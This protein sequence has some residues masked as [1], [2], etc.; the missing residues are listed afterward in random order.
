M[1]TKRCVWVRVGQLQLAIPVEEGPAPPEIELGYVD[2]DAAVGVELVGAE[3]VHVA[4][5]EHGAEGWRSLVTTTTERPDV[6]EAP[7]PS[8]AAALYLLPRAA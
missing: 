5:R 4:F 3:L 2:G 1:G 7:D 6:D 8:P